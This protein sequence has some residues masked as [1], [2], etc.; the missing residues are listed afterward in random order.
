VLAQLLD[1]RRA[2][3]VQEFCGVGDRA[4]GLLERP[5]NELLLDRLQVR[6]EVELRAGATLGLPRQ[7]LSGA[8]V[9]AGAVAPA[10]ARARASAAPSAWSGSPGS[11]SA[12]G[13]AGPGRP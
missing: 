4:V 7:L 8:S 5:L 2:L 12:W 10:G 6:L 1:E 13:C 3:E 11:R 9:G